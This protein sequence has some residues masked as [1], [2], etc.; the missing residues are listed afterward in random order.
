MK[1]IIVI[2]FLLLLMGC[3]DLSNTPTKKTEEFLKKYQTLDNSVLTDLKNV[4]YESELTENQQ[5]IYMDIMKKHYQNLSYEIKDEM[6]DGDEASVTVE[7]TVTDFN[8]TLDE[9]NEYMN[10][11]KEEFYENDE[12]SIIKFN[13]YKLNKLK[14]TKDKVKYTIEIKLT[15]INDTWTIDKL[16]NETYEKINGVYDY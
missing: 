4:V 9:A 10:N 14:E 8:K 6:I 13:D 3:N 5:E 15:K 12:Y 7:I 1:K 11:H 16:D 2:L